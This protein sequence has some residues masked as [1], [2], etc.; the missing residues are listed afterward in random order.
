VI[1]EGAHKIDTGLPKLDAFFTA[2]VE[3]ARGRLSA[4]QFAEKFGPSKSGMHRLALYPNLVKADNRSSLNKMYESAQKCVDRYKLG[5]WD[6]WLDEFQAKHATRNWRIRLMGQGFFEFVKQK[7]ELD[8][9]IP[10]YIE[11]LVDIAWT[12]AAALTGPM[13][14]DD[15]VMDKT[16]FVRHYTHNVPPF[17][18]AVADGREAETP[19]PRP[20]LTIIYRSILTLRPRFYHPNIPG[21]LALARRTNTAGELLAQFTQVTSEMIDEGEASLVEHGVLAARS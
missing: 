19:E 21:L 12:R 4:E 17:F 11:E 15:D 13:P 7:R 18:I 6:R 14:T 10:A 16:V 5:L 20:A 8:P 3:Y 1:D 2:A 9:H